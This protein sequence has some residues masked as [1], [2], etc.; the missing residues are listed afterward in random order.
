M[1]YAL[2]SEDTSMSDTTTGITGDTSKPSNS[3]ATCD[4]SS[5]QQPSSSFADFLMAE[6]RLAAIRAQLIENTIVAA[7]LALKSGLIGAED[8]LEFLA[9]A[10]GA[11]ALV[12]Q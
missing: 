8:G 2:D 3:G 9:D 7:D 1:I 11:L 4:A 10:Q 6:L 12:T 5:L